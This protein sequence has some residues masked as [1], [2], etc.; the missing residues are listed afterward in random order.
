MQDIRDQ[1]VA[2]TIPHAMELVTELR[3]RDDT[4]IGLVTGKYLQNRPDSNLKWQGMIHHGFLSAHMGMSL[5][6]AISFRVLRFN[7]PGN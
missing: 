1:F 2:D 5:L 7:V 6:I 3:E 4:M